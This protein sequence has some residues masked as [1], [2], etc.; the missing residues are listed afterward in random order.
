MPISIFLFSESTEIR[1]SRS[2]FLLGRRAGTV[3][4]GGLGTRVLNEVLGLI[5][6]LKAESAE[7]VE[8]RVG[9]IVDVAAVGFIYVR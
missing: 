6:P 7:A 9:G 2:G 3:R 4:E 8:V 5:S 1:T